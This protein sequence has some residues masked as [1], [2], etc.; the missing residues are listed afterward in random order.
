MR[1]LRDYLSDVNIKVD[2]AT[3]VSKLIQTFLIMRITYCRY[4]NT[5][6]FV[7]LNEIGKLPSMS[8]RA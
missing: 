6:I 5:N 7:I 4:S 8:G 1:N 3:K 2:L